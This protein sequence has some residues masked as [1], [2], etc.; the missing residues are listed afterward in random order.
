MVVCTLLLAA[1][2]PTAAVAGARGD[3]HQAHHAQ[4]CEH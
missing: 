3:P 2:V 4:H 1:M